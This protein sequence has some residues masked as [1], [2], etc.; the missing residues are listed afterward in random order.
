MPVVINK[1]GNTPPGQKGPTG[2][3]SGKKM[4]DEPRP[5]AIPIIVAVSAVVLLF[6]LFMYHTFVNPLLPERAPTT[7]KVAPLPGYPDVPPYNT[8]EWQDAQKEGRASFISGVPP[9]MPGVP[10]SGSAPQPTGSPP[11]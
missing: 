6:I 7:T 9:N 5:V 4:P 10:R 1:G 3:K 11:R 8:K 2:Q